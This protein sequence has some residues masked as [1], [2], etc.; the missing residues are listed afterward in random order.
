MRKPGCVPKQTSK[1]YWSSMPQASGFHLCS[2]NGNLQTKVQQKNFEEDEDDLI[3]RLHALLGD[4][5]PL[6]AGRLPG[7]TEAEIKNYWNTRL[8]WKLMRMRINHA[9]HRMISLPLLREQKQRQR[10]A[11]SPVDDDR[12]SDEAT[13]REDKACILPDLNL[14]LT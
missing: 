10:F 4:R 5:W 3:I 11:D 12:V 1:G 8:R 2:K 13:S 14:P 9:N 6:I 7:R